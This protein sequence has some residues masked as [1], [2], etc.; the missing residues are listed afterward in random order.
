MGPVAFTVD[1]EVVRS[2]PGSLE[3]K[4]YGDLK[5]VFQEGNIQKIKDTVLTQVM[6]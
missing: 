6:L 1:Y 2:E 5:N 3:Y 4:E